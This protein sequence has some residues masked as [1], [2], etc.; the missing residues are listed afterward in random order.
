MFIDKC[1]KIV[2]FFSHKS[3]VCLTFLQNTGLLVLTDNDLHSHSITLWEA[4]RAHLQCFCNISVKLMQ[5]VT[6]FHR[7]SHYY[8]LNHKNLKKVGSSILLNY[9]GH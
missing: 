5:K 9:T 6:R 7:L 1:V 2:T 8:H 3:Q 4:G